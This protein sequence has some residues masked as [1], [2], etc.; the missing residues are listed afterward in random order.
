MKY[1]IETEYKI[2]EEVY[3]RLS[4]RKGFVVSLK[5]EILQPNEL[6]DLTYIVSYTVAWE[7]GAYTN[8]DRITLTDNDQEYLAHD[9]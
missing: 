5:I 4:K 8:E 2:G 9:K 7:D 1:E 6:Q 3:A